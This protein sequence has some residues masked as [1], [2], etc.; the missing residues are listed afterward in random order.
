MDCLSVV[1]LSFSSC[2][3]CVCKF[4]LDLRESSPVICYRYRVSGQ[5]DPGLEMCRNPVRFFSWSGPLQCAS[6][7]AM[8]C[9]LIRVLKCVSILTLQCARILP[10]QC[11]RTLSERQN[12]GLAVSLN[13]GLTSCSVSESGTC[14]VPR[15]ESWSVPHP[16]SW[17][18]PESG[19]FASYQFLPE[20]GSESR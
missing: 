13:P 2:S 8:L 14:C 18:V 5:P 12:P 6:I 4:G 16:G 20:S 7:R 17:S 3:S 11:T 10:L 9:A 19:K 1:F 15:P